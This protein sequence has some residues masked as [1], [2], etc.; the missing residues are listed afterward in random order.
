MQR[1]TTSGRNQ[2][3]IGKNRRHTRGKRGDRGETV[4]LKLMICVSIVAVILLFKTVF[5]GA[6]D[7]IGNKIL[8]AISGDV[9]YKSALVS[10]GE[11]V[12]GE[13]DVAEAFA[14]AYAYAFKSGQDDAAAPEDGGRAE[15]ENTQR[16][17]EI[18]SVS[19][20]YDAPR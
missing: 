6:A 15:A 11:A 10:I 2:M 20:K 14:E 19:A 17:S 7:S 13:R 18:I 9:D 4:T 12:S 1:K 3:Y 8:Y 16:E 5:P